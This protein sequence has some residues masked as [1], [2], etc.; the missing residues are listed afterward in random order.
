MSFSLPLPND[1]QTIGHYLYPVPHWPGEGLLAYHLLQDIFNCRLSAWSTVWEVTS[2]TENGLRGMTVTCQ[3]PSRGT[4]RSPL[5]EGFFSHRPSVSVSEFQSDE[6]II[7]I[8]SLWESVFKSVTE[9]R[10]FVSALYL[11]YRVHGL[12]TERVCIMKTPEGLLAPSVRALSTVAEGI[13]REVPIPWGRTL[14]ASDGSCI[15]RVEDLLVTLFRE[16]PPVWDQE[17]DIDWT[18]VLESI[19]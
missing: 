9:Y 7:L 18:S 8:E 13:R 2:V 5:Q 6:D 4:S 16:D 19:P 1:Q 3:S 14:G 15:Y 11:A 10:V 12:D 17:V